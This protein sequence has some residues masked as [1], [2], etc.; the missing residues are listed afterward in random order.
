M[1]DQED[2]EILIIEEEFD[3]QLIRSTTRA[4]EDTDIEWISPEL[5]SPV[6]L[7]DE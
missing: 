4:E 5:E 6:E 7:E 3:E 2:D 1:L